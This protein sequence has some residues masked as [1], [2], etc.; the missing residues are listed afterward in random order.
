MSKPLAHDHQRTRVGLALGSGAARG[1]A[2]IGVIRA[3]REA[4]L[5]PDVVAGTS[6]GAITGVAM[7]ADRL[8][9]LEEWARKL[10]FLDMVGMLD[11]SL[12]L[13]GLVSTDRIAK[14]LQQD[15]LDVNIEDLPLPFACVATNL[16]NG[17]EVWLEEGPVQTAMWASA[18]MPGLFP[19]VYRDHKW[20]V[21]GALVNPV[22]VSVCRALGADVVIA[23][24]LNADL[25]SLPR[26]EHPEPEEEVEHGEHKGEIA[27]WFQNSLGGLFGDSGR[28]WFDNMMGRKLQRPNPLEV[29]VGSMD[30]FQDRMARSRLAGDPPDI[31]IEPPLGVFGAL[32]FQR[33]DEMIKVGHDF[34]LSLLPVI[35]HSLRRF[36]NQ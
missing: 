12:S 9:E 31:I 8:D 27:S 35:E 23:V 3:L 14:E 32:D 22:P 13:G 19:P 25:S 10:K 20:L 15:I 7:L 30:I 1:W 16:A 26:L 21:D 34:T 6:I 4:G 33:A 18:A 36:E 2:L 11:I 17:R 24:N 29:M 28:S 5:K